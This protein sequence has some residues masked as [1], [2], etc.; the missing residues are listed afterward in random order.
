MSDH[1]V[2]PEE[3]AAASREEVRTVE[4]EALFRVAYPE[5]VELYLGEKALAEEKKK[6]NSK[7]DNTSCCFLLLLLLS[8]GNNIKKD[9]TKANFSKRIS[10]SIEVILFFQ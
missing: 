4:E 10:P 9:T 2:F 6:T 8:V 1:Y 7:A 3:H 5:V